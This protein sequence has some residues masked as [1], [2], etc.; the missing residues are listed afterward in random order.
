MSIV[1]QSA[2]AR[3]LHVSRATVSKPP[4]DADNIPAEMKKRV[5]DMAENINYIPLYYAK[6]LH[7]KKTN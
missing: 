4:K 7:S 1:N 6:S 3:Q 5:L 2:I